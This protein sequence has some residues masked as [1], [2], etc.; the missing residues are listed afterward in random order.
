MVV[1]DGVMIVK[2]EG[3]FWVN[4]GRPC[5]QLGLPGMLHSCAEVREPLE[6]SFGLVNGVN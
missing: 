3:Q 4:L 2:E 5:N 6:L 1:L